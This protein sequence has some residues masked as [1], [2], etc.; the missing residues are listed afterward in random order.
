MKFALTYGYK[1][2]KKE[3]E[4]AAAKANDIVAQM[5]ISEQK[6][7]SSSTKLWVIACD[8]READASCT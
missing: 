7:D 8:D 1:A 2:L 5:D 3:L 4:D 6:V